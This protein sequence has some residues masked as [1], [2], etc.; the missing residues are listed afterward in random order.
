MFI[1]AGRG[2]WM[3]L[4]IGKGFVR[5]YINRKW[6][7][8]KCL[9]EPKSRIMFEC[10]S[11]SLNLRFTCLTIITSNTVCKNLCICTCILF[12]VK[13]PSFHEIPPRISGSF[14]PPHSPTQMVSTIILLKMLVSWFVNWI[15]TSNEY[16]Y[17]FTFPFW[18]FFHKA[19]NYIGKILRLG[20]K[21]DSK[22]IGCN[23][24]MQ[25]ELRLSS[26]LKSLS[27]LRV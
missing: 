22:L 9:S 5:S 11:R 25:T 21:L 18:D 15:V 17:K 2:V 26:F 10:Y 1:S 14:L 8:L 4:C 20:G 6:F 3:K 24:S 16:A 23:V 19:I 27:F 12:W 7:C 13:E